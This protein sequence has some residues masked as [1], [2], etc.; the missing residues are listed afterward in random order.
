M[1]VPTYLETSGAKNERFYG[2][3]GFEVKGRYEVPNVKK[4][5]P[6]NPEGLGGFA[7]MVR[8]VGGSNVIQVAA[9]Q[10]TSDG[11]AAAPGPAC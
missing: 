10:G 8:K 4:G 11:E 2:L 3:N 6:F 1:N 5:K 7:G 9:A